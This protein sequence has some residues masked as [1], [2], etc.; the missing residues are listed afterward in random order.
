V[1][2]PQRGTAIVLVAWVDSDRFAPPLQSLVDAAESFIEGWYSRMVVAAS[3]AVETSLMM[4]VEAALLDVVSRT[5]LRGFLENDATYS[6]QLNILLPILLRLRNVAMM[7]AEVMGRLNRLRDLRNRVSHRAC[8]AELD[9]AESGRLL[10][11]AIFAT[12]FL[13]RLLEPD[14]GPNATA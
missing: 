10:A 2:P 6:R 5:K 4:F 7:P 14:L 1:T 12:N 13:Q 11:A 8:S 9:Q 3:V